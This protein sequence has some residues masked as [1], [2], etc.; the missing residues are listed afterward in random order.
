M[1][2]EFECQLV[3]KYSL[4]SYSW[5]WISMLYGPEL[6]VNIT[7]TMLRKTATANIWIIAMVMVTTDQR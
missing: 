3:K 4:V 6:F 7:I 5:T 2:S 1:I